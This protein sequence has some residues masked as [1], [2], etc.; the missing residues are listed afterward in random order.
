M[1]I[2]PIKKIYM[3]FETALK[4]INSRLLRTG[5]STKSRTFLLEGYEISEDLLLSTTRWQ[6][7][8]PA[9]CLTSEKFKIRS[10]V[11]KSTTLTIHN[12]VFKPF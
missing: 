6:H 4:L 12:H 7:F 11:S 8:S 2:F 10:N 9:L 3:L 5:V 1:N